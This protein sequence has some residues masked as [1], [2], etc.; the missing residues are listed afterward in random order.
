[1][2]NNIGI[3]AV[4]AIAILLVAFLLMKLEEY[5]IRNVKNH[6]IKNIQNEKQTL[7]EK[8]KKHTKIVNTYRQEYVNQIYDIIQQHVNTLHAKFLQLVTEDDY[9]YIHYENYIKEL[10]YFAKDIVLA[11]ELSIYET[12]YYNKTLQNS[13]KNLFPNIPDHSLEI[14]FYPVFEA[15]FFN[16]CIYLATDDNSDI[17][18]DNHSF[19]IM[20]DVYFNMLDKTDDIREELIFSTQSCKK[21]NIILENNR[22]EEYRYLNACNVVKEIVFSLYVNKWKMLDI[23]RKDI[24]PLNYEKSITIKLKSLGFNARTTKASGDQG[25]DVIAKKNGISFA[26]QCKK[27]S[28]PVGNKAVQEANAGRDFYNCDYGVVVSNAGFTKSA[29]QAANACK[30]ILLND[31]QLEKLLQYS[32]QQ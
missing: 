25:A 24:T 13:Y 9:G 30:V 12:P 26:I 11:R 20:E 2:L 29:R 31:T 5:D 22:L 27:Y 7:I 1:M 15:D 3:I 28:K 4:S 10:Y 17:K 19:G 32:T 6:E 21:K 14:Y 18:I 23:K 8:L 16:F